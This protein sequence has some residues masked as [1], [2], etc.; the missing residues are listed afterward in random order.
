MCETYVSE[1]GIK[2]IELSPTPRKRPNNR[3]EKRKGN[4]YVPL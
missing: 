3:A 4:I 2:K 1:G